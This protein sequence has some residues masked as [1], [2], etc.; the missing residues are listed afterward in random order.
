MNESTTKYD[1]INVTIDQI[2]AFLLQQGFYEKDNLNDSQTSYMKF[3]GKFVDNIEFIYRV[4]I[5][6]SYIILE[7]EVFKYFV[8]FDNVRPTYYAIFD[9]FPSFKENWFRYFENYDV[10]DVDIEESH[11]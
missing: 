10:D 3:F 7:A 9:S 8:D 1:M 2:T 6:H 5:T 4:N 11:Q